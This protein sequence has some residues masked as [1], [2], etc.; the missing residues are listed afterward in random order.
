MR[1]DRLADLLAMSNKTP[2]KPLVWYG[3]AMEYRGRGRL[4]EAA[5]AFARC[6]E[7]DPTYVP[8]YFQ[9]AM[10]LDEMSDRNRAIEML[11]SGID[12]ARKKADTHA[13]SE[14][15]SQLELWDR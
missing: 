11:R 12:V 13:L 7:V 4:H 2:Q 5:E 10:T 14:M 9:C 8:A 6:L 15:T 1:P 3:L